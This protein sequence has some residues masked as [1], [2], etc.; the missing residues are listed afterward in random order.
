MVPPPPLDPTVSSDAPLVRVAG[1]TK[2]F[3][4][5]RALRGVSLEVRAGEV[6]ALLGENGAGKST[7]IKILSGVHSF[8][9][10]AIEI[11]GTSVA[12]N[13]PA[14]SRKAGIAVVY[15]DLSLV[16]SLTVAANLM[17][18]R[19]PTSRFGFLKKRQLMEEAEDFLKA[20]NIPLDPRAR[21]GSLPFAYRQMTEI[22]KA[23]MGRVRVLV[24]DEP[25]SALTS[26][27]E[28]ILFDAIATVVRQNVGVIYVTHRLN[29]V[30]RIS[31]RVTVLRDGANVGTFNTAETD[32][33]TLVAAIVGPKRPSA[34]AKAT[35]RDETPHQG[36]AARCP[37]EHEVLALSG[38]ANDRLRGVELSLMDGEIH[39]LAGLI[40]SGRT[41]ILETIFGLRPIEKGELRLGGVALRMRSPSRRSKKASRLC[42]R[43]GRCKDW[44]W[45]I[46]SSAISACLVCRISRGRVGFGVATRQRRRRRRSRAF[47]SR[48]LAL[49]PASAIFPA[50]TN[51][52]WSSPNGTT[53]VRIKSAS[54]RGTVLLTAL[55]ARPDAPPC[56]FSPSLEVTGALIFLNRR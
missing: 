13:S 5:V 7:L 3:G 4:G 35:L 54:P 28:Q 33:R 44:C 21:V 46:R 16:E 39:G 29:E 25:T 10:G 11:E 2:S 18:N 8:D 12:F 6:H 19:E 55:P 48:R 30:F 27:E 26:D 22:C 45:T 41:E 20:H 34:E 32:M 49:Q 56:A 37:G 14:E 43:I 53:L 40:G 17:L 36:R 15:Q 1:M 38:I 9:S 50:A 52:R 42:R 23:L 47:R 51:K 31:D 24:L